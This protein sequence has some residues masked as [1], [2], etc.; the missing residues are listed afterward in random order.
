MAK[1]SEQPRTHRGAIIGA[2]VGMAVGAVAVFEYASEGSIVY[3]Y[4]IMSAG[5]LGGGAVGA[6]LARVTAR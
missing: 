3:R 4:L 6:L 1:W 5:L 2:F